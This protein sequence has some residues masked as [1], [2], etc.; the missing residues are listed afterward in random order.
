MRIPVG[1]S[2]SW[3]PAEALAKI[4]KLQL[5]RERCMN[6]NVKAFMPK[7]EV[8]LVRVPMTAKP[9]ET[10]ASLFERLQILTDKMD[11]GLQ[12]C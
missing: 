8:A 2:C 5:Y 9:Q 11:E 4:T 1:N 6:W 7:Q 10:L 3:L 12:K